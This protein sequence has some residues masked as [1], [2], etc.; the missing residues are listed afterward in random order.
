MVLCKKFMKK[1]LLV[2]VCIVLSSGVFAQ[3]FDLA[4]TP[5]MGWNSWNKF[6]CRVNEEV[7]I[8]AAEAMGTSGNS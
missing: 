5:P 8:K 3:K 7:V 1:R 2:L 4:K 6:G